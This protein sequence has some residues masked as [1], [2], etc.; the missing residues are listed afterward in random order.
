MSQPVHSIY[1]LAVFVIFV[2]QYLA[3]QCPKELFF[4]ILYL[5]PNGRLRKI[6]HGVFIRTQ[7]LRFSGLKETSLTRLTGLRVYFKTFIFL[8]KEFAVVF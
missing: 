2:P 1:Y 4:V 8:T 6:Y 5:F 3:I 7:R